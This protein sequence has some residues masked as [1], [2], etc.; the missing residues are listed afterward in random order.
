[1]VKKNNTPLRVKYD[2]KTTISKFN[3]TAY[4]HSVIQI[5]EILSDGLSNEPFLLLGHKMS[6]IFGFGT[7]A[8]L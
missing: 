8:N 3:S 4:M 1:M 6:Q 2:K 7:K 5:Y